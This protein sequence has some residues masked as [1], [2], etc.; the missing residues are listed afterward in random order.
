MSPS[1]ITT[2]CLRRALIPSSRLPTTRLLL[3]H[4][5]K[6]TIIPAPLPNSGPLLSRRSDRELPSLASVNSTWRVW[7]HLPIVLA[8]CAA[9]AAAIFNYQK[10]NHSVVDSC[11]YALRTNPL[12]REKLGREIRFRDRMP[13]ISGTIN[14]LHGE[15]DVTFGVKGKAAQ[16]VMRFRCTRPHGQDFFQTDIWTLVMDT[17]EVVDLLNAA[18]TDPMA[19]TASFEAL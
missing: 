5:Q 7:R 10:L 2:R 16:G 3:P 17:G 13:W 19:A 8:I 6:R 1:L 9:S 11:M 18:Q 15:V 4:S 14:S 12:A